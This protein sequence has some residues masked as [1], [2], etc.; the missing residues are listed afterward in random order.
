M[1]RLILVFLVVALFLGAPFFLWGDQ[2]EQ[3]FAREGTVE[4]LREFGALAWL[5]ALGLLIADLA[6]PIPAAAI[7]AALGILYGPLWGGLLAAAGSVASGLVGYG[8]CRYLGRPFA[9]WL[10]GH[11][12]LAEGERLFA[13]TGGWTVVLSRWLPILAEVIACM[14][15][16]TRMRFSLFLGALLCGSLPL[17]FAFAAIGHLGAERPLLTL[18]LSVILPALLWLGVRPLFGDRISRQ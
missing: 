1:I 13:R 4:W 6:L 16:L 14:A 15:G 10:N 5:T 9:L 18:G 3:L 12:A 17:G 8:L 2:L 11:K 7:M